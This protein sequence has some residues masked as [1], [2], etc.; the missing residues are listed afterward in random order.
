MERRPSASRSRANTQVSWRAGPPG[1]IVT[2]NGSLGS[3]VS[4]TSTVSVSASVRIQPAVS[5][6]TRC[7]ATSSGALINDQASRRLPVRSVTE[8]SR[9]DSVS[10]VTPTVERSLG[11]HSFRFAGEWHSVVMTATPGDDSLDQLG[12]DRE[13]QL[14]QQQPSD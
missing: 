3:Y 10:D 6:T 7:M 12:L 2:A 8:T 5:T 9:T 11:A 14:S 13:E 1:S 4:W